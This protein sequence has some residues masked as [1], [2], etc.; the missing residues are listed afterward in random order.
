MEIIYNILCPTSIKKGLIFK[1]LFII[2]FTSGG[3]KLKKRVDKS[4]KLL[5]EII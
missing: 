5:E 4:L 1:G 2:G 3:I